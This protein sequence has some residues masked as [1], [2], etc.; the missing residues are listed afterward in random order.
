MGTTL[1]LHYPLAPQT[2]SR[3]DCEDFARLVIAHRRFL[4]WD[5]EGPNPANPGGDTDVL[6]HHW[7]LALQPEAPA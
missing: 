1:P 3:A 6:H 4:D 2:F 5:R 7:H